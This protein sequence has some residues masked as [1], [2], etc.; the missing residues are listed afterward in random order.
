MT[1]QE[2]QQ[3]VEK[4]SLNYFKKPFLHE[5][6]FNR[7]LKTTGG[8]YHLKG[9]ALDFNPRVIELYGEEE[10]ISVIKH[11]LCHY[12]LHLE[13]RGYQHKDADFKKLLKD[14]GGSRYAPLL[15]EQI[16]QVYECQ[17]CGIQIKRRKKIN[18]QRYVCG[19]CRGKLRW[20]GEESSTRKTT[21]NK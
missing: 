11:E 2:L 5:A 20:K 6:S 8:R 7:R 15:I 19:G 12:H 1:N 10:L 9:H 21:E 17:T 3:L 18:T 16:Y 13:G 4:V 14:T